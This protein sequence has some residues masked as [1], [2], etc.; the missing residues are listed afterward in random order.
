MLTVN[1]I[2][3]ARGGSKGIPKK[4]I[5]D[6]GG[7]PLLAWA[8]ESA[9][10]SNVDNVWVSTDCEEISGIAV[11]YGANVLVRPAEI[12]G[13]K[14]MS[15]EAL[16]HFV[17][18]IDT[19]IL[20]FLQVT[21]PLTKAEDINQAI[22]MMSNYDSVISVCRDHGGWLCG[23][24]LWQEENLTGVPSYDVLNRPMRQDMPHM[25]R[26]NG[27]IYVTTK[28]ALLKTGCRV[29]GKIGLCKMPRTRSFEIDDP[30][31][32]EEIRKYI[33]CL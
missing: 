27:A 26:E 3:P 16:I 17:N 31:D 33:K 8:I 32:L 20:V 7:K 29:S 12:S 2:I 9:L 14:S 10:D 11:N 24:F 28:T 25:Y 30:E 6:L 4:N 1:A 13:E 15:E 19:D 18:I 5:I 22:D 23:G 21:S